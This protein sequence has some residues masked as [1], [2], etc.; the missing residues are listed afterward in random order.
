M[1]KYLLSNGSVNYWKILTINI[2][3]ITI[4]NLLTLSL[5]EISRKKEQVLCSFMN[6]S[7]LIYDCTVKTSM[8]SFL[9]QRET[10]SAILVSKTIGNLLFEIFIFFHRPYYSYLV[11]NKRTLFIEVLLR[12][13]FSTIILSKTFVVI[14]SFI[15]GN[16]FI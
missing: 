6:F 3:T 12:I 9:L 14:L 16:I 13:F 8:F 7:T 4:Y 1:N 5:F 2:F 10:Q 15:I 11:F